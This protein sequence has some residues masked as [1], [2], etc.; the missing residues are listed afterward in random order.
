MI[1]AHVVALPMKLPFRG[2]QVRHAV[3]FEAPYGWV[4]WSP[5]A[6]YDDHEALRWLEATVSAATSPAPEPRRSSIEVNA[7]VPALD[8]AAAAQRVRE[9]GCTTVK[10]KVAHSGQHLDDDI[11]RVAAVRDELGPDGM[12]RLDANTGWTL[13]QAVE[14]VQELEQFGLEYLEQPL[15]GADGLA[16][17]RAELHR[18]GLAVPLAADEAIRRSPDPLAVRDVADIAILKAQPLGGVRRCLDLAEKLAMPV[19]VSSALETSVG[20]QLS[21]QLAAALPELRYACGIHTAT[22]F[23]RDLTSAPLIPQSG[24]LTVRTLTP[25]QIDAVRANPT[26]TRWWLERLHRVAGLRGGL[27]A[28]LE[29][30][31]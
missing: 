19:V 25:D 4:E 13:A 12:I 28:M 7:I 24:I 21:L 22:L 17:L 11:A 23:R 1:D 5:F 6:E 3:V 30:A 10:V 31:S 14:A 29:Q 18:R 2:L 8:P 16:Q 9:S 26:E 15:P 20:L 27:P